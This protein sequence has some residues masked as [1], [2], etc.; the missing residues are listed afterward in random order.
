MM[1]IAIGLAV[2]GILTWVFVRVRSQEKQNSIAAVRLLPADAIFAMRINDINELCR[3]TSGTTTIATLLQN[4]THTQNAVQ[5]LQW[6]ADSLTKENRTLADFAKQTWWM[7]AHIF[8]TQMR[9]L[10]AAEFPNHLYAKDVHQIINLLASKGFQHQ[11]IA[12]AN[13]RITT[14]CRNGERGGEHCF[15]IAAVRRVLL[16]SASRIL[17]E[18]AIRNA[19]TP[20]ALVDQPYFTNA[21][22]TAGAHVDMNLYFQSSQLPRYLMSHFTASTR[23]NI[24][25]I[26]QMSNFVVL[27]AVLK[28]GSVLFNGFIFNYD[29]ENSPLNIIQHQKPQTLTIPDILPRSVDAMFSLSISNT[30]KLLA[31]YKKYHSA[32]NNGNNGN[33]DN[34]AYLRQIERLREQIKYSPE[35]LFEA[36]SPTE[37]ALAHIPIS[38]STPV[39]AGDAGKDQQ[40]FIVIKSD[41]VERAKHSIDARI[42]AQAKD[43]KKDAATFRRKVTMPNN[44]LLTAYDNPAL[45]LAETLLGSLLGQCTDKYLWYFGDYIVYAAST[46]ALGEFALAAINKYTLSQSVN[47]SNYTS[48]ESNIFVYL[49]PKRSDASYLDALKPQAREWLRQSAFANATESMGAQIRV[50]GGSA[51][52]C[53]VFYT[54][55]GGNDKDNDKHTALP[56]LWGTRLSASIAQPPFVVKNHH[57]AQNNLLVQDARNNL[58]LIDHQGVALWQRSMDEPIMGRVLQIDLLRNN[59]LQMVFNTRSKIYV[60]DRLGKNAAP[61]ITLPAAATAPMSVFDYDHTRQYRFFVPCSNGSGGRIFACETNGK[62]LQ[63]FAPDIKFTAITQPV[64]HVRTA[65]KDFIVVTDSRKV[66]LL[67]RKGKLR[68]PTAEIF[69]AA[70]SFTSC[71]YN[72]QGET[73]RL[74][75]STTDGTLLSISLADGRTEKIPLDITLKPQHYF[76]MTPQND[77]VVLN[78]NKLSVY[79]PNLKQIFNENVKQAPHEKPLCWWFGAQ[80]QFYSV[81]SADEGKAYLWT[82]DGAL[83]NGF[84]MAAAAPAVAVQ[85][86][87]NAGYQ[88]VVGDGNGYLMCYGLY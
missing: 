78:G 81:Y 86:V 63:G 37:I 18:T 17:V 28:H 34:N 15:H 11:T 62:P 36:L 24:N 41:N 30:K 16:V 14:F 54:A 48:A 35:E 1:L 74:S 31:D 12:Y 4:D 57:T 67:D 53:S 76:M 49:N 3:K 51:V 80:T 55:V 22:A 45:G 82:A 66:H 69:P 5:T 25:A 85:L 44:S 46:A 73:A 9:Y 87:K 56:Y 65:N 42:A 32:N 58:Y 21:A 59:K 47:I 60:I 52:Y 77:Y 84:P 13:E 39:S 40:W 6:I 10:F 8:D 64:M 29:K 68:L 27:D 83:V 38:A 26:A 19:N 79:A 50:A 88:V 75:V 43:S 33:N 23:N 61:P 7:S 72:A 70:G 71:E 2:A 20:D